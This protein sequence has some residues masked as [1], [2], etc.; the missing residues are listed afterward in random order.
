[1]SLPGRFSTCFLIVGSVTDSSG[2]DPL[3][4]LQKWDN[5]VSDRMAQGLQDV[6]KS[7]R[8]VGRMHDVRLLFSVCDQELLSLFQHQLGC[9]M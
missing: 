5:C 1:M 8:P 9:L 3:A 4:N 7:M 2:S 6:F